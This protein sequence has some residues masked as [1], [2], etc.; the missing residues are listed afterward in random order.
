MEKHMMD[1][2]SHEGYIMEM[3]K[4]IA[5]GKVRHLDEQEMDDWNGPIHYITNVCSG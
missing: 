4:S 5:E 1:A 2:G 3:R